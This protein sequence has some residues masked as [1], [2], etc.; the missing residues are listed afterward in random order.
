MIPFLV[1]THRKEKIKIASPDSVGYQFSLQ[2]KRGL[3]PDASLG[4]CQS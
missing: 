4:L 1:K 3:N 2:A